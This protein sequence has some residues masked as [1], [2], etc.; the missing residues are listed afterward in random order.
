MNYFIIFSFFFFFSGFYFSKDEPTALVQTEGGPCAVIAP[1]QAFIIKQLLL[2]SESPT[3]REAKSDKC[4][5]LLVKAITEIVAQAS[6][7]VQ[8]PEYSVVYTNKQDNV[9]L[10]N[11]ELPQSNQVPTAEEVGQ[12]SDEVAGEANLDTQ[13]MPLES[14]SFHS[15][16]RWDLLINFWKTFIYG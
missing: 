14:E 2:D 16:L 4:D 8:A 11:G 12:A 7:N 5:Q 6:S 3:W 1:V 15:R 13:E 10:V 9:V